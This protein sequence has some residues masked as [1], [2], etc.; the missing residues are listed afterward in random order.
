MINKTALLIIEFLQ[1]ISII[2][3]IAYLRRNKKQL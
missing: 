1:C 2:A 3:I